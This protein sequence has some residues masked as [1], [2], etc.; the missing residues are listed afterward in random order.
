MHCQAKHRTKGRLGWAL[1][2]DATSFVSLQKLGEISILPLFLRERSSP[3]DT[4]PHG[5]DI[6]SCFSLRTTPKILSLQPDCNI[7]TLCTC[8]LHLMLQHTADTEMFLT[9]GS[10]QQNLLCSESVLTPSQQAKH[11][12]IPHLCQRHTD[13]VKS[14]LCG[15]YTEWYKKEGILA[16]WLL[17]PLATA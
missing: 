17:S 10:S 2:T 4:V 3:R 1:F 15:N 11:T 9:Y 5:W 14:A 16:Q 7:W 6:G 13:T 12:L 8:E